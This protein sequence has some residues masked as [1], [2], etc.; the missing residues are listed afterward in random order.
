[1]RDGGKGDAQRPLGVP[2]EQFDNAWERIFNKAK[3]AKAIDETIAQHADFLQDL[4]THEKEC[5]K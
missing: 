5:G 2:M 4:A 1:M 3:I